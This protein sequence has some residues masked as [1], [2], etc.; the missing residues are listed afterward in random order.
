MNLLPGYSTVSVIMPV[1][2]EALHIVQSVSAVLRQDYPPE[3]MEIIVADGLSED[4]TVDL[5]R[6]LS[7]EKRIKIICN[8]R[9][10][11]ASGLN[12]AI[13]IACG[14]VIVRVDGHT[15]I[16]PDYVR[17]C[18][19]TLAETQADNVGGSLNPVGK[20]ITGHSIALASRSRFA[21]PTIFRVSSQAQYTDTVYMGA[22]P[23]RVFEKIGLFDEHFIV[24]EDYEFNFR[25]R[26]AGGQIYF[27]P[28]ICS[29]YYGQQT[30]LE[31]TKQYF[32]YGASKP[33][34]LLKHPRS[35]RIRHL[36]APAFVAF[37]IGGIPLSILLPQVKIG[38]AFGMLLYLVAN[39]G[40]SLHVGWQ[41]KLSLQIRV[42]WV[43]IAIHA[44]WGS[45]FW[46]AIMQML[47]YAVVG[48]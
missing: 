16:A 47:G 19:E 42:P 4:N 36:A 11:Q 34:T 38:W 7:E 13:R 45:G 39:I 8:P 17:R 28:E 3:R 15:A 27:S 10:I 37:A 1:R 43:F 25:I 22:W 48:N 31:L 30:F 2:N 12:E 32:R 26:T 18:I 5:I 20:T 24:N 40:F 14:D 6:R 44:A 33:K 41:Q 23:R 29:A 46:F 35:L 21:V 9:K